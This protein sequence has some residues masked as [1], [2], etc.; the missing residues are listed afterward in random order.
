M[1]EILGVA[2]FGAIVMI[3]EMRVRPDM[4]FTVLGTKAHEDFE[5]NFLRRPGNLLLINRCR[6]IE[7]KVHT[8]LI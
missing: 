3:P 8:E 4:T 7:A 5:A 6:K 2:S 1:S